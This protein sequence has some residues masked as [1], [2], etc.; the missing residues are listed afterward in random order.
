MIAY[1]FGFPPSELERLDDI[2]LEFWYDA[3][4]RIAR[5]QRGKRG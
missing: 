1:T 2:E 4:D 3:A 5:S